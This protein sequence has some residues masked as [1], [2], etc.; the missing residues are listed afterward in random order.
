MS[1]PLSGSDNP[2]TK[3]IGPLP[4]AVWVLLAVGAFVAWRYYKSSREPVTVPSGDTGAPEVST[5]PV[6]ESG[7]ASAAGGVGTGVVV[8]PN[9]TP[10]IS[11]N[12][13]WVAQATNLLVGSGSD[14]SL[15]STALSNYVNGR[16][17]TPAQNAIVNLAIQKLGAPPEGVL[18]VTP[19][20]NTPHNVTY[21][22]KAGDTLVNLAIVYYGNPTK[23]SS[24]YS[25]NKPQ[26]DASTKVRPITATTSLHSGITL[27]IP[28]A[29]QAA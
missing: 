5:A 21:R 20:G 29:T 17:V 25:Y 16:A 2:F 6:T 24:I 23:W 1:E 4:G 3:K 10:P 8:T 12:A 14:P 28:S 7:G 19:A 22:T 13:Q 11:T 26:I 15:V 9:G 27:V 18:P